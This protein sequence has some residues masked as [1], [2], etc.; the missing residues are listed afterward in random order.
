MENKTDIMQNVL[1]M[2]YISF[3]PK[4]MCVLNVFACANIGL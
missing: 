4:Y 3:S 2:Q 1:E